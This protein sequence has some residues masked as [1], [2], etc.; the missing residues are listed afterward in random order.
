MSSLVSLL[1]I[2]FQSLQ[3]A[4]AYFLPRFYDGISGRHRVICAYSILPGKR[5]HAIVFA[6]LV[7]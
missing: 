1:L 2:T 6:Q 4:V 5:T 3:I 7:N